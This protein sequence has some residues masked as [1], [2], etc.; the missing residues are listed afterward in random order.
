MKSP[1]KHEKITTTTK[2]SKTK[3][4]KTKNSTT[5]SSTRKFP[6]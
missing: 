6:L 2:S 1:K 3:S 5:K 4:T